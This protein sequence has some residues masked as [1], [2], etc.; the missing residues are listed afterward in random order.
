M[1]RKVIKAENISPAGAGFSQAMLVEGK[2]LY[3]ISGQGPS[4]AEGNLVG[5]GDL[6]AQSHQVF[7][8][9]HAQLAAVGADFSNVVKFTYFIKAEAMKDFHI[10][11]EVRLQ[12]L[13]PDY[14]TASAVGV[15]CLV[16]PD[17]LVEVEALA[18]LD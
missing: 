9:L 11:R 2:R 1:L 12:Y 14:P 7:R 15:A 5:R 4:D 3:F 17:W 10:F 6:Q 13:Q 18:I 16:D 8:N